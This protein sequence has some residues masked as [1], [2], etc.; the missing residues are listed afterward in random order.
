MIYLYL[1]AVFAIIV[2]VT[3][4]TINAVIIYRAYLRKPCIIKPFAWLALTTDEIT[5]S[6]FTTKVEAPATTSLMA[7]LLW[8]VFLWLQG[9]DYISTYINRI[10]T[11]T[12]K[13]R[14]TL[15]ER[16]ANYRRRK[17]YPE[18]YV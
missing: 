4:W 18:L 12:N 1:Y 7:I 10:D 17:L 8:P 2:P 3:L 11:H 6:D 13:P 15:L 16:F 9:G 14:P 5:K